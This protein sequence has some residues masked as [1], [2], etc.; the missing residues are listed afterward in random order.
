MIE[1]T[2]FKS[3]ETPIYDQLSWEQAL[4]K[5]DEYALARYFTNAV[6]AFWAK[7]EGCRR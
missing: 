7:A 6:V 2:H 5:G 1:S 4:L 3:G